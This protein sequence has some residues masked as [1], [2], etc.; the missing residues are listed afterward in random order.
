MTAT[1]FFEL[2]R[3][4]LSNEEPKADAAGLVTL[5]AEVALVHQHLPHFLW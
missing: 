3:V 2:R 4:Y 1:P 5:I